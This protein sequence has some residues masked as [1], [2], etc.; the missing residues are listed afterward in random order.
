MNSI[1][2]DN[3]FCTRYLEIGNYLLNIEFLFFC[4]QGIA[5]PLLLPQSI[6]A[7]GD[8][9]KLHWMQHATAPDALQRGTR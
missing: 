5:Y 1:V 9:E 2:Y 6:S 4:E 7:A 3:I 8:A